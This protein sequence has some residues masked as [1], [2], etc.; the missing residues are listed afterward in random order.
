MEFKDRLKQYRLDNNI[1]QEELASKLFVSRQAISKYETGR[2]YPSFETMTAIANLIGIS[3]DELISKE[4]LAKETIYT[5]GQ[6]RKNKRNLFILLGLIIAVVII[7]VIAIVLSLQK[8]HSAPIEPDANNNAGPQLVGLVGSTQNQTPTIDDLTDNKLFGYCF[9]V[10][11]DT[12]VGRAYN[13]SSVNAQ[14]AT[15]S[16]FFDMSLIVH[17]KQSYVYFYEVYLDV[18]KSE[19]VFEK[20]YELYLATG[21]KFDVVL[22]KDDISWRFIFDIQRIDN[23][24]E[25]KLYEYGLNGEQLSCTLYDGETEYTISEDCLYLVVE[26]KLEDLNGKVY[27]NREVIYNSQISKIFV[28][29]LKVV[30]EQGFGGGL[31]YIYKYNN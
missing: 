5:A 14:L 12:L 26:E 10:D 11:V 7:S 15:S 28:Y 30:N 29:P 18:E 8:S 21:N 13:V 3:L 16:Y 17:H 25:M 24:L 9:T 23:L 1:T 2:S 22:E 6:M 27:Y 4:E 20:C 31:L 19:Y